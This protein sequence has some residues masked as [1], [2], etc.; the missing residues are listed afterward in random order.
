MHNKNNTPNCITQF[1]L[2][3]LQHCSSHA[4]DCLAVTHWLNCELRFLV[5]WVNFLFIYF[6]CF[7]VPTFLFYH[8]FLCMF[9]VQLRRTRDM[10]ILVSLAFCFLLLYNI[11]RCLKYV[12]SWH[13]CV[14]VLC[15]CVTSNIH[16]GK[17]LCLLGMYLRQSGC[18]V[19][20]VRQSGC[21]LECIWLKVVV[22]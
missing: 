15:K 12:P 2:K 7:L 22:L 6:S 3:P 14:F 10:L 9:C 16:D 18:A 1:I 21:V 20:C 13:W 4:G 11:Y 17:R 5:S 8:T 19:E